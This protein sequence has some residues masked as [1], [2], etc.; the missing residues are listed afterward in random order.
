MGSLKI[1]E[2]KNIFLKKEALLSG[3]AE[4]LRASQAGN[5]PVAAGTSAAQAESQA[6]KQPHLVGLRTLPLNTP[7]G[8][9]QQ[10]P[11]ENQVRGAKY[12]IR[13]LT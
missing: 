7:V 10:F 2:G 4:V 12:I 6:P 9:S 11:A 5:P 1:V 8:G 13:C 3:I